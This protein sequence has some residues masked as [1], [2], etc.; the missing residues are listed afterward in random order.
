MERGASGNKKAIRRFQKIFKD[1][2]R[3]F[4]ED[5]ERNKLIFLLIGIYYVYTNCKEVLDASTS[6]RM[7]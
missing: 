4:R 6:K 1:V 2:H 5:L 3:Y 7:G